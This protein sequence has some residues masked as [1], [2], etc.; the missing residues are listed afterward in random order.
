MDRTARDGLVTQERADGSTITRVWHEILDTA[1]AIAGA[2]RQECERGDRVLIALPSSIEYIEALAGCMLAGVIPVPGPEPQHSSRRLDSM[3]GDCDP[4]LVISVDGQPV[5]SRPGRSVAELEA[6]SPGP[7][8][9][10]I[11]VA[12]LQYTSGST[13]HPKGVVVSHDN[14]Y[15][16]LRMLERRLC[17][18][19]DEIAIHVPG[20]AHL[21]SW[22][23]FFHDMGLIGGVFSALWLNLSFHFMDPATFVLKPLRWLRAISRNR[24]VLS[25]A[26][27]FAYD[28]CVARIAAEQAAEL[29]LSSWRVA[30]CGA[31]PI[32]AATV[33]QFSAR[34][35]PAGFAPEAFTPCYGMAESTLMA[36]CADPRRAP[37]IRAA[38]D[39]SP[40]RVSCGSVVPA[41]EVRVRVVDPA[42]G[43]VLAD[44]QVGEI[45]VSSPSVA[46]G[47]WPDRPLDTGRL[48]GE[49]SGAMLRTGDLGCVEEGELYIYGRLKDTIIVAGRNV[50]AEDVEAEVTNLR[51]TFKVRNAVAF[52]VETGSGEGIGVAIEMGPKVTPQVAAELADA[53]DAAL[54]RAV[55]CNVAQL[56]FLRMGSIA[57]TSSGK[58]RR[59]LTSAQLK[60]GELEVVLHLDRTARANEDATTGTALDALRAAEDRLGRRLRD[61]ELDRPLTDLG[62]SSIEI[63]TLVESLRAAGLDV[64]RDQRMFQWSIARLLMCPAISAPQFEVVTAGT[65]GTLT[66]IQEAFL[67]G[68]RPGMGQYADRGAHIY[69]E[70]TDVSA[71]PQA[72]EAALHQLVQRHQLLTAAFGHDGFTLPDPRE[73]FAYQIRV[74]EDLARLRH[75]MAST[76][77]DP[78]R[79]PL[80]DIR[81][82]ITES[83]GSTLLICI[84]MLVCDLFSL[85]TL[86]REWGAIVDGKPLPPAP[87][88]FS[89]YVAGYAGRIAR[90]K[91]AFTPAPLGPA[92]PYRR[93]EDLDGQ[94]IAVTAN[95]WFELGGREAAAL[96]GCARRHGVS[97]NVLLLWAYGLVLQAWSGPTDCSVAAT[98]SARAGSDPRFE[99]TVGDFTDVALLTVRDGPAATELK[100]L[101]VD[102]LTAALRAPEH[103]GVQDVRRQLAARPVPPERLIGVVFTS[104]VETPFT[105]TGAGG[106]SLGRLGHCQSQTPQVVLDNVVVEIP[107]GDGIR[108]S[109]DSVD[110]AFEDG[111]VE[112]MFTAYQRVVGALAAG[113]EPEDLRCASLTADSQVAVRRAHEAV[114][115]L[116]G[117][118]TSLIDGFL[119]NAARAPEATALV[120]GDTRVSYGELE[121]WTAAL[122]AML[123]AEGVGVGDF[124]PV[125]LPRGPGQIAAVVAVLRAGA[126]YVPVD[127]SWPDE[128]FDEI[129]ARVTAKVAFAQR[130]GSAVRQFGAGHPALPQVEPVPGDLRRT[131]Y[132]IFTSGS[133]G[134]PKGVEIDHLGAL[135]TIVDINR[136]RRVSATDRVLCLSSLSFDLSVYDIFGTLDA[137]GCAVLLHE[138]EAREP[139]AWRRA[140]ERE[141]VTIWNSVPALMEMFAD[142]LE[143]G[144]HASPASLRVCM[145]SGDWIPLTLPERVMRAFP[146]VSLVSLGGA[147]EA[148]IWSI[149]YPVTAIEP[150]W[151]SVPYGLP[152]TN[153]RM[154]VLDGGLHP[155]PD[156][157]EGDLY[158]AGAGLAK[159]Y[160]GDPEQTGRAFV[161][162]PVSGERLYRTGDRCYARP[163]GVLVFRGRTDAQVKIG[164]YRI[165]LGEIEA[166][167][168]GHP[169]VEGAVATVVRTDPGGGQLAAFVRMAGTADVDVRELAAFLGRKL[170]SYMIPARLHPISAIPLS[171]NGKVDRSA[172]QALLPDTRWEPTTSVIATDAEA[173]I[174]AAAVICFGIAPMPVDRNFFDLGLTSIDLVKLQSVLAAE[175]GEFPLRL[176]FEHPTVRALAA[177]LAGEDE[178]AVR[179]SHAAE[180]GARRRHERRDIRG[181]RPA[182]V[183]GTGHE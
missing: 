32:R 30:F 3:A 141:S 172:L 47:Y 84:D 100:R 62:L 55:G 78:E 131:A 53:L 34:F 177:R 65:G 60:R 71:P 5:A 80:F 56:W 130:E 112:A 118:R 153:Q 170:P 83:G 183:E 93:V 72:L 135:N 178:P 110:S 114:E 126:A 133:T 151:E 26:P 140:V 144:G 74:G 122:A 134:R 104:A 174:C 92:L 124:V 95:R 150:D 27:N 182:I 63:L 163:D 142:H 152:L 36:T 59:S 33:H 9:E 4:K 43:V 91:P 87:A 58:V 23:P 89:E 90:G 57:L 50:H 147:T 181:R 148:S 160:F 106:I 38:G 102:M 176:L 46:R 49:E 129:C 175:F 145:L 2:L 149:E 6:R 113:I 159:G 44:G 85:Y 7:L 70:I 157:V 123:R 105:A 69:L 169:D 76:A 97:T 109:W 166:C 86:I 103:A 79:A 66:P 179:I 115:T 158:I 61:A 128:R 19:D 162:H 40:P 136:R 137:G 39:G 28:L 24:A 164:G 155:C 16:N 25:V 1:G 67:V 120:Q 168:C 154:L 99:R 17:L 180:R 37:T 96:S 11:D 68:R 108:L 8:C 14:L 15:H 82:H 75:E 64:P 73:P 125:S 10:P 52:A 12:F 117:Q 156:W 138:D 101:Q 54:A 29:D 127:V 161:T 51:H 31:E 171:A 107:G 139:A 13:A 121:R 22:L 18:R 77:F 81:L 48:V 21:V 35:G 167:L 41:D 132:V 45:W 173:R 98:L 94:R 111:V 20:R 146:G 143:H 88:P 165:E 42:M 119:A 116:V